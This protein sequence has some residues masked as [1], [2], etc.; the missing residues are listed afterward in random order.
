VQIKSFGPFGPE[1]MAPVFVARGLRDA[2]SRIAGNDGRHLRVQLRTSAGLVVNGMAFS[3]A[4]AYSDLSRGGLVD[5]AFSLAENVWQGK[6]TLQL[7][8][9]DFRFYSDAG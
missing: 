9:K 5:I 4:D 3:L 8:V 6:K 1:N 2:G 7:M